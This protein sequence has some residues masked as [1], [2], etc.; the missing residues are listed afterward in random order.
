[1]LLFYSLYP[2]LKISKWSKIFWSSLGGNVMA[3]RS[4]IFSDVTLSHANIVLAAPPIGISE[5]FLYC[6][7]YREDGKKLCLMAGIPQF[8]HG[9][10]TCR[11]CGVMFPEYQLNKLQEGV[12]S[13]W[14]PEPTIPSTPT[15]VPNAGYTV[16]VLRTLRNLS[17]RQLGKKMGA[18]RTYVSKIENGKAIP[19]LESCEKFANALEV[20]LF[21]FIEMM[22]DPLTDS[23]MDKLRKRAAEINE[24]ER[25]VLWRNILA[26]CTSSSLM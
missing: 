6:R 18:S 14:S 16:Y 24:H 4:E 25:C 17:Q 8:T 5:E 26:K 22:F 3:T 10:K 7:N 12:F 13:S 2:I 1:M 19:T 15:A 21:S 20:T 9:R 11:R 23:F